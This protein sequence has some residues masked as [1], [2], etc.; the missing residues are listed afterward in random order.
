MRLKKIKSILKIFQMNFPSMEEWIEQFPS[1]EG[2]R[3][4]GGEG[5]F[6]QSSWALVL[7][8]RED[9]IWHH[10]RHPEASLFEAVRISSFHYSKKYE[11]RLPRRRGRSSQWQSEIEFSSSIGATKVAW[12]SIL[13]ISSYNFPHW[14]GLGGRA[15]HQSSWPSPIKGEGTLNRHCEERSDVAIS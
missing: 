15:F 4:R 12:G 3:F 10:T 1:V 6:N 11:M 8:G 2:C 5:A 7:W 13:K 14:G 9:L